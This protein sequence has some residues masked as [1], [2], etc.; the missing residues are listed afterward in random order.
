V[1]QDGVLCAKVLALCNSAKYGLATPIGSIEQAVFYL[2]FREIHRLVMTIS[3]GAALSPTLPGYVIEDGELWRHSLVTAYAAE[4]VLKA[5]S[6]VPMDPSIAYTAGLV[7]D[8]GKVVISHALNGQ[9]QELIRRIVERGDRPLLELE[10]EVLG[11]N[12]AEI[13]AWLLR[14]WRL[15]ECITEAVANH[16]APPVQPRPLLSAVVHVADLIAHESGASPG[17]GSFSARTDE[18]AV[19]ALGLDAVEIQ[20]LIVGT[21]DALE[22][23]KELLALT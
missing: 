6:V 23:V 4:K 7:H 10:R 14:Q 12:H 17:I 22:E 19:T 5:V 9:S 21:L 8:L 3:F 2:G 18:A 15:P 13:G 11:V 1:K 16:H 20:N